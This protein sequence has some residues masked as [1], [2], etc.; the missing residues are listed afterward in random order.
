MAMEDKYG[1][2]VSMKKGTVMETKDGQKVMMH[3]NEAM[4][5]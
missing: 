3:G 1:R 4:L 5:L 2:A